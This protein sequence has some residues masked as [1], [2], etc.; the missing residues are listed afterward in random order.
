MT[1]RPLCLVTGGA[2]FIGSNIVRALLD[3]GHPVRIIDNLSTGRRENLSDVIQDVEVVEAD[4]RDIDAVGRAM[5]GV[6][7]VLHQAAI[8]SVARSLA[9]PLRTHEANVTGT[10]N[11]LLAAR[12]EGVERFVYAS[13]SSVYGNAEVLPVLESTPATP[14]SPYGVSKLAGE[15]YV[16]AFHASFG[17]ATVA[18][19]YFNVYGPRQDPASEYAAV[20]PRFVTA[21]F[22]RRPATIYGDGEQSRDFTF[23]GDVVSANLLAAE[24]Q[25]SAWGK[26]FNIATGESHRVID[27]LATILALLPGPHSPPEH[28]PPRQGEIRNSLADISQANAVLG[29]RPSTTFTEGI[30]TTVAWYSQL[31]SPALRRS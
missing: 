31:R 23:V 30:E 21:R 26:V 1:N 19:R 8:P 15:R 14:I 29:Y 22:E 3:R 6:G 20:V 18:L 13:S 7:S 2:G 5:R 24:A 28:A 17:L 12:G 4:I 11:L 27:L 16:S 9:D 10:M 25:K